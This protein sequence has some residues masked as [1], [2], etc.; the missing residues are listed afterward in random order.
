MSYTRRLEEIRSVV[1]TGSSSLSAAA[2]VTLRTIKNR[3]GNGD[4]IVR[5]VAIVRGISSSRKEF[6]GSCSFRNDATKR[7]YGCNK[8][9]WYERQQQSFHPTPL[10]SGFT[11]KSTSAAPTTKTED[12]TT[13]R[14]YGDVAR[15]QNYLSPS[16]VSRRMRKATDHLLNPQTTISVDDPDV[17]KSVENVLRWWI[18]VPTSPWLHLR[19]EEED[20]DDDDDVQDIVQTDEGV[21]Y[22]IRLL[23]RFAAALPQEDFLFVSILETDLLNAVL[24]RWRTAILRQN[25]R[26]PTPPLITG[27]LSTRVK[28]N[29]RQQQALR[30]SSKKNTQMMWSPSVMAEKLEHYRWSSLVQP[31]AKSF[32]LLLHA[33]TKLE[34][35]QVADQ[36]LHSLLQA[37]TQ[38]ERALQQTMKGVMSAVSYTGPTRNVNKGTD[39]DP[40][41]ES[42]ITLSPMVDVVSVS[43]VMKGWVDAG[44]PEKA[45][46]WLDRATSLSRNHPSCVTMAMLRPNAVMYTTVI[47]GWARQGH[48][49]NA[50]AIF[51]QQI[52]EFVTH[53]NPTARPDRVTFHAVLDAWA[54]AMTLGKNNFGNGSKTKV[55]EEAPARAISLVQQLQDLASTRD[56]SEMA[57]NMETWSKL[58]GVL[59]QSPAYGPEY[60][61]T[62][63][64]EA[65]EKF[66]ERASIITYNRILHAYGQV[67]QPEQAETFFQERIIRP[68]HGYGPIPTKAV[69]PDAITFNSIM[70]TWAAVA[71]YRPDAAWKCEEWL[72]RMSTGFGVMPSP[73]SYSIVLNAWNQSTAHHENAAERA[74]DLLRRMLT[75]EMDSHHEQGKGRTGIGKASTNG[76]VEFPS[77][78]D[79]EGITICYNTAVKAWCNQAMS[80]R[81]QKNTTKSNRAAVRAMQLFHDLVHPQQEMPVSSLRIRP[82]LQT[83]RTALHALVGSSLRARHE[84][85]LTV[86]RLMQ[87][88]GLQPTRQDLQL[89]HRM[90]PRSKGATTASRQQ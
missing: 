53:D 3:V 62:M 13:R 34:G 81:K 69:V 54:K 51:Q 6:G 60:A 36:Y 29:P 21:R 65:E 43:T 42:Q 49:M 7:C 38:Q 86:L 25:H 30:P 63:L 26:T 44:R 66:N 1:T 8:R 20:D 35:V 56:T 72:E 75:R 80:F 17:W 27:P 46:E 24:T 73:Y 41:H 68:S 67:R 40:S 55:K 90:S 79:S 14:R 85:A 78:F 9:P 88:H 18:A 12:D 39:V 57:P 83:F 64:L 11:V 28:S 50:E 19:R 4:R 10:Q 23:D 74:E 71:K 82:N 37:A 84:S 16:S 77:Q 32:N 2:V 61:T 52:D 33:M 89:V 47:H 5:R 59:V 15:D 31:D 22:C 87:E 58:C 48:A 76:T 45:Q 70:A